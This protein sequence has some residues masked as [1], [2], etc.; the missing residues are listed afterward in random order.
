M[1]KSM[2]MDALT[3]TWF[4]NHRINLYL[5]QAIDEEFL[6]SQLSSKGRN[7]GEQ[8][9]HIHN[10]RLMWLKVAM[11]E[12][13]EGIDKIEKGTITKALLTGSLESS[14]TAMGRLME[15]GV[16]DGKIKG[17]KPHPT[18]FL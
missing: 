13:M 2:L 16:A 7:V 1:T 4:I 18:A 6:Q 11:P 9:A 17:F 15:K 5:L 12:A 3:E 10:V 14:A 8:L